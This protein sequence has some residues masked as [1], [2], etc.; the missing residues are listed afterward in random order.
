MT[1]IAP[2]L[3]SAD[4]GKIADEVR[5][6][7]EAGADMLHIDVMDGLFV[8]NITIGP[9]VIEAIKKSTKLPLDVHL[10]IVNPDK[11][12]DQFV[13]AGADILTV[14]VEASTHL[15]RT[16]WDIKNRGIKAGVSLNPATPI[17]SIEEIIK[18]LDLILI[19]SV[20]PGFGGQSFISSSLDKIKRTKKLITKSKTN[21]LIEVD[22]G[23]KLSNAREIINAG[24][25]ILVMGSEFFGQKDYKKFMGKLK[26]KIK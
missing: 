6:A 3:L 20:N 18:D 13:N 5:L 9:L 1:L 4:F 21:T 12:I 25:D 22:G 14:H 8:P 7:E 15:H 19:M 23:V 24:A 26:E 2:S 11:Y 17:Y 16:V 10:M